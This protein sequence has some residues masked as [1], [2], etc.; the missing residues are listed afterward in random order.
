[1]HVIMQSCVRVGYDC[2]KQFF[3]GFCSILILHSQ[4]HDTMFLDLHLFIIDFFY[5][6]LPQFSLNGGILDITRVHHENE[7]KLHLSPLFV[8]NSPSMQL[9]AV[10]ICFIIKQL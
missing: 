2:V 8:P 1:M 6:F 7:V 5:F 10:H 4:S 9:H 3:V